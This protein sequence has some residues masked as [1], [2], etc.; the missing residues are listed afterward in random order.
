M[1]I[2]KTIFDRSKGIKGITD[3]TQIG[4][5]Y[6]T[7]F[8]LFFTVPYSVNP[9]LRYDCYINGIFVQSIIE[10]GEYITG[11]SKNTTYMNIMLIVVDNKNKK[12][13]PSNYVNS[14]TAN[15]DYNF[16]LDTIE[17]SNFI[18]ASAISSTADINST[19]QLFYQLKDKSLYSKILAG[20][21]FKGS[22]ANNQ[23]YNIINPIDSNSGFRLSFF[24]AGTFSSLGYQLNGSNTFAST[25]FN[26]S[27][28]SLNDV[29]LTIVIGTNNRSAGGDVVDMGCQV[30]ANSMLRITSKTSEVNNGY[31]VLGGLVVGSYPFTDARGISTGSKTSSSRGRA[32]K[33][34]ILTGRTNTPYPAGALPKHGIVIGGS[35]YNGN[36]AMQYSNQRMQMSFIHQGLIDGEVIR[37][38]EIIN[39]SEAIAGRKTW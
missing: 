33:N 20:W 21:I 34:A 37:L 24:G 15:I 28:A 27:N 10:S 18:T 29:G 13:A 32:F 2:R 12:S 11:L 30:D 38:H 25:F 1:R 8:Q 22:T 7:A 36:S 5:I 19:K 23:K 35:S 26:A 14:S 9:V 31:A 17:A 3:L 4:G 6:N 16:F 39:A